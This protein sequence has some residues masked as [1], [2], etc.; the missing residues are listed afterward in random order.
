MYADD[1]NMCQQCKATCRTCENGESCTG[2]IDGKVLMNGECGDR[3][4]EWTVVIEMKDDVTSSEMSAYDVIKNISLLSGVPEDELSVSI[5]YGDH[6]KILRIIVYVSGENTATTIKTAIEDMLNKGKCEQ[7]SLCRVKTVRIAPPE[8]TE[9]S[10]GYD[11][12]S[13]VYSLTMVMLTVMVF[14]IY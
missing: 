12:V 1:N 5:E 4:D 10:I 14:I 6:N 13:D 2:C 3:M 8:P 9:L 11:V 7:G